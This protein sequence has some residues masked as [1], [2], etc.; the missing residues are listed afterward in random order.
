MRILFFLSLAVFIATGCKTG[1][2][3]GR[4]GLDGNDRRN[5]ASQVIKGME[6]NAFVTKYLEGSARI[7]LESEKMNIGGTATIRLEQDKAIWV[8]VKKF[9]LEGARALIRPDSFFVYNRLTGDYTAEPL[10][11]IETK[12][13]LPAR[14]DLLQEIVLGNA[15][16]FTRNLKMKSD[17]NY[18]E[19]TGEDTRYK[20]A[21]VVDARGYRLQRMNLEEIG[22]DRRVSILNEDFQSLAG[23][24]HPFAH[25]RT[26][27][28]D[29]PDSGEALV[30]LSFSR[31]KLSG[32]L[33]MP[34][35]Q[36]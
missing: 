31:V 25:G 36:R 6:K 18:Y 13:N 9:G 19:L 28:I 29:S 16:F 17:D 27:M 24:D 35:R 23:N 22:S 5:K 15:V 33:D 3:D 34:F 26:I 32:P 7:K 8:S 30:E 20:T 2:T 11:Y 10:S 21:Y 4:P 1:G 12:Y 14:F